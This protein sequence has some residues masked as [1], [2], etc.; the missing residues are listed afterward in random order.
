MSAFGL[1]QTWIYILAVSSE[2]SFKYKLY[3]SQALT[4]PHDSIENWSYFK[5]LSYSK[6]YVMLDEEYLSSTSKLWS[7]KPTSAEWLNNIELKKSPLFNRM[8][9][10]PRYLWILFQLFVLVTFLSVFEWLSTILY[11]V[12]NIFLSPFKE[13][14]RLLI[15]SVSVMNTRSY[16][17]DNSSLSRYLWH[18]TQMTFDHSIK[19]SKWWYYS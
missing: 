15:S 11:L 6:L 5:F 3:V 17:K 14:V 13:T 7:I 4:K 16:L 9:M 10:H 18:K 19:T 12:P 1:F 8:I 2:F